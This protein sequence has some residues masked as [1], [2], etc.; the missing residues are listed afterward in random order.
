MFKEVHQ[1]IDELHH[2]LSAYWLSLERLTIVQSYVSEPMFDH[3]VYRETL[4]SR[5]QLLVKAIIFSCTRK[6]FQDA[7]Y[8]F[9]FQAFKAFNES[10]KGTAGWFVI[11]VCT[12]EYN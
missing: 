5:L 6:H 2:N 3:A 7:M 4:A 12:A 8:H 1:S 10:R 9:Y 11:T